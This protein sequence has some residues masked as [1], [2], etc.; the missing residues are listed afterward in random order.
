MHDSNY[1][2]YQCEAYTES[3][4]TVGQYWLYILH[5]YL[6]L[7][8]F[9]KL[10]PW[11]A[12]SDKWMTQSALES[13]EAA[14]HLNLLKAGKRKEKYIKKIAPYLFHQGHRTWAT[15]PLHKER[16]GNSKTGIGGH[17]ASV[18]VYEAP[19]NTGTPKKDGRGPCGVHAVAVQLLLRKTYLEAWPWT[20]PA[21][22]PVML[23]DRLSA[24]PQMPRVSQDLSVNICPLPVVPR[25]VVWQNDLTMNPGWLLSAT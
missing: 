11:S 18:Q 6:L 12:C 3:P 21:C 7:C 15:E 19:G 24:V 23:F 22:W 14:L 20:P 2:R 5:R 25:I 8:N 4:W 1:K 13:W 17:A 16:D 10:W 9:V